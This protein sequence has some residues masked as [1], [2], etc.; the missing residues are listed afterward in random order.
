MALHSATPAAS[1]PPTTKNAPPA[2]Q[3]PIDPT[4]NAATATTTSIPT[5]RPRWARGES[6]R[7]GDRSA[8]RRASATA[9]ARARRARDAARRAATRGETPPA[10]VGPTT[11]AGSA[12]PPP[13]FKRS[14]PL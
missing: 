5:H 4:T 12:G 14:T 1:Q 11:G 8:G 3:P 9:W 13:P 6:S 10:A 2:G 7:V